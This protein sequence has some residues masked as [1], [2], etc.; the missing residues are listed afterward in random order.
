MNSLLKSALCCLLP[1][2]CCLLIGGCK[3]GTSTSS[4]RTTG[5]ARQ[6]GQQDALLGAV[7][8]QLRDLPNSN[9]L[10]LRPPVVILDSTKSSDGQDVMALVSSNPDSPDPA[11]VNYLSVPGNNARFRSLGVRSGD[12]VKLFQ[13]TLAEEREDEDAIGVQVER[14]LE[15]N[16]AQVL[17]DNSLLI[18]GSLNA[19]LD[20]PLRIEV[21]RLEDTRM[22]E[23]DRAVRNYILRGEP[24]LGW[25][26]TPDENVLNQIVERLNQWLRG[27]KLDSSWQPTNLLETLPSELK[28]AEKLQPYLSAA[29]LAR[30]TFEPFEGRLLQEAIWCRDISRW[31]RGSE[32][33]KL[34]Q[35]ERLFDWVVRNIQLEANDT[36]LPRRPW[37]A[38][39][40]GRGTAAERAWVMAML[41]RQAGIDAV[42]LTAPTSG[43]A[44]WL[45]VGVVINNDLYLF[46]PRLGLPIPGPGGERVA[47]LAQARADDA[48]LRQFD[49]DATTYPATASDLANSTVNLVADQFS[50]SHR[51]STL[52]ER[53]AGEDAIRLSAAVDAMAERIQPL[54]AGE[55][56]LWDEP[57]R[58]LLRQLELDEKSRIQA[59]A[60]FVMFAWRPALWKART[61]HFRGVKELPDGNSR[62]VLADPTDDHRDAAA[63]YMDKSV[64][65]TEDVLQQQTSPEKQM[66]Y[67]T[68]KTC[69][70][71]WLGLL[72]YDD[73]GDD[74][75]R[76]ENALRWFEMVPGLPLGKQIWPAGAAYN[77]ARTQTRLGRKEEAIERLLESDSPQKEGNQILARQLE[78]APDAAENDST[79]GTDQ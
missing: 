52:E 49:L 13:M 23:I 38:L 34:K 46:D 4:R 44:T 43:G 40:Y 29:A 67:S 36:A 54:G 39:V 47:T 58:S 57:F 63:L 10:E 20:T 33:D 53:L 32:S 42:I 73:S 41:C 31:V 45:S 3:D 51:A 24:A 76:L 25:E 65:P 37:Q 27:R 61:L 71:Y 75:G 48:V 78:A 1:A 22:Q 21:W 30:P 62:D 12:Q 6:S 26:P 79:E 64:R 16:V 14:A 55:V 5:S 68:A 70:T 15:L 7:T 77:A 17:N 18:E 35:A 28:Q 69:A 72:N 59:A 50:L 2:A 56:R 9:V 8:A 66:V 74:T 19:P 60:Q 11:I